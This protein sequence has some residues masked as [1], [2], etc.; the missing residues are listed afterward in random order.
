MDFAHRMLGFFPFPIEE[1][2]TDHGTEFTYIFMPHVQKPHPFEEFLF[3]DF[4][5]NRRPNSALGWLTPLEKLWSFPKYQGVTPS[6]KSVTH[7]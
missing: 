5:N 4:Y 7:V 3:L 2:Q 1:V 6:L